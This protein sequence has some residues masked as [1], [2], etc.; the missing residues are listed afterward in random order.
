MISQ[1]DD[2]AQSNYT[3]TENNWKA[4]EVYKMEKYK[5]YVV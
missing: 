3:L 2:A 4:K 1:N 5:N